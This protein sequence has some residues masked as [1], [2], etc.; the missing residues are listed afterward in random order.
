MQKSGPAYYRSRSRCDHQANPCQPWH[1]YLT[2]ARR[3]AQHS[4]MH[5]VRPASHAV[6]DRPRHLL[7]LLQPTSG[8]LR[9]VLSEYRQASSVACC[10]PVQHNPHMRRTAHQP[11]GDRTD[12]PQSRTSPASITAR[13]GFCI[14]PRSTCLVSILVRQIY[15]P[16]A[17]HATS[18]AT[19]CSDDVTMLSRK[20]GAGLQPSSCMAPRTP[21]H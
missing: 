18:S 7:L 6:S 13:N 1:C 12:L 8:S 4:S 19:F 9:I 16:P 21:C 20:H 11:R 2:L 17:P 15:M 14:R 5:G 3:Q 10:M